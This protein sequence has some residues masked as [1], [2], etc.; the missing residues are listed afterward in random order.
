MFRHLNAFCF[1]APWEIEETAPP[2]EWPDRGVIQIQDYSARYRE[3]LDLVLKNVSL[4][5]N[6][7]EKVGICGRTGEYFQIR[8]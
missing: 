2:S 7:T 8:N 4:N 5:I 6:S 1:K 3:G